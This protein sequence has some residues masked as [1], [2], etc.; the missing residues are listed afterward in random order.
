MPILSK[1]SSDNTILEE[2][3]KRENL[4]EE[5]RQKLDDLEERLKAWETRLEKKEDELLAKLQDVAKLQRDEARQL[6]IL[7]WEDKLKEDIAKLIR[8]ST[9]RANEEAKIK[10]RTILVDAMLHAATSYVAEYTISTVRVPDEEMK[11]RIIGKEGRNI[12]AFEK[13]TGVDVDLD[14]E[15]AIRL[16][17]VDPGRREIARIS[18]A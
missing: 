12:R 7:M 16:S 2:I 18:L 17:S 11:G 6:V 10:A 14:E 1:P 8:A 3:L 5:R 9:D 13:A 15:G 4:L